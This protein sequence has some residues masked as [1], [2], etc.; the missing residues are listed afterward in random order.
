MEDRISQSTSLRPTTLFVIAERS[1]FIL[2]S[3]FL[4]Y[5]TDSVVSDDPQTLPTR[6]ADL[7]AQYDQ[8]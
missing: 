5:I 1:P 2:Y 7:H 8:L 3:P 4:Q 6:Q